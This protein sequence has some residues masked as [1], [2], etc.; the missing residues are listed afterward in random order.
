MRIKF[1][2]FLFFAFSIP[3]IS[4]SQGFGWAALPNSP[5]ADSINDGRFEDIYFV[6]AA[7]GYII[8]GGG[9]I[10]K[11]TSGGDTWVLLPQ[12]LPRRARCL[13]FFTADIG[14]AGT[15]DSNNILYRTSNGGQ[16]W[17]QWS[18]G[19]FGT[20]PKGVCGISIID[21]LN[22]YAVG[23]YYCP[24]NMIKTTN[25][26]LSWFAV[27]IDTALMRSAIDC[28]FWTKD[29]GFVVGG[30]SPTSIYYN[31]KTSVLFTSNGGLTFERKY[32]SPPSRPHEWGWKIHFISRQVGY[33][34]I[35]D[36]SAGYFLKTTDGGM[37]WTSYAIAG[38]VNFE[39]IGFVNE[40]TGWIGGWGS[41]HYMPTIETTNGGL[42]WHQAGW[43]FNVNRFRFINDTLAFSVGT[44]V[45]KYSRINTGVQQISYEIPENYSLSQNYPNPFNP[46]T[47]IKYALRLH[48]FVTIKVYDAKGNEVAELVNE[49]QEP[50]A[51]SIK[52]DASNLPSGIYYYKL[53][54]NQ[55]QE[56]RKMVLVK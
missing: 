24:S 38:Q 36:I 52:F 6:N 2:V 19:I 26:G 40:T 31:G 45:Y 32:F 8:G 9:K 13:G 47:Y 48:D 34:S 46:I 16:S 41:N 5:Q 22:A 18:S 37:N 50:G 4:F 55:F 21:S 28:K 7:T 23:R 43:G 17:T 35:E 20:Q 54:S 42:N 51:F 14:V 33:V 56:T 27:N 10:Y 11:T 49:V 44:R 1:I 12:I 3:S 29:S 53:T 15:L 25:A 39:G 30:Y